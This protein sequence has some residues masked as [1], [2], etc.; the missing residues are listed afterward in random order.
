MK[1]DFSTPLYVLAPLAG[2]TDLPFRS[3]VKKFGVDLTVSEMLSSN[4]LAYQSKKT[5]K[6]L[7]K[8]PLE[9]PYSVQISGSDEDVIRR[10]VELI[11]EQEGIT[12]IDLNCGCPV[13]KV[14]NNLAGSALL[15]D[16]PKMGRAIETIKRYSNKEY[17]SVKIR[18]GFEAKNHLEIAKVCQ[19]SGVDFIAV[20]GRTRA[21]KFKAEVDYD[22]IGEIKDRVTI[23]VI[24]NGDID[25]PEKAKWVLEHTGADG[26]MVGRAA[27]GKPWIFHQMKEGSSSVD[28]QLVKAIVL[29]H[30][31]QM[32]AH[33][34]EY[35]ATVFRKH[36]HTYSK[37][38]YQGASAFRDLVNRIEDVT[39]MR[40]VISTFFSQPYLSDT[41]RI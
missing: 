14:V 2:F 24:A 21:G 12:A 23:P 39:E 26:I 15:T 32:I 20:H 6:M 30:F 9:D 17:T 19:E 34:G 22:A 18:L 40:S 4:A 29:E 28:S 13:P 7:A 25:S 11:N 27:I 35:G 16:L 37:A 38:G 3:V 8:S 41:R 10:A 5:L 36:L 33:Y 31:D 1:I